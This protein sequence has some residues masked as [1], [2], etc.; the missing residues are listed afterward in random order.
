MSPFGNRTRAAVLALASLAGAAVPARAASEGPVTF[1]LEGTE[2]VARDSDGD[3]LAAGALVG[4]TFT[5]NDRVAGRYRFRI[6]QVLPDPEAPGRGALYDVS[7]YGPA[8]ARWD[9]LC[10]ADAEGRT[11]AIVV[12]GSWTA[13]GRFLRAAARGFS[14]ACTAGAEAK[15]VRFG[16]P[17]WATAPDGGGMAPYHAAC[18]RMVRADY[19]GDGTPHTV[20]GVTIQFFD[21]AAINARPANAYGAFEALWGSDGAVCMARSRRPEFPIEDILRRCPRLA[22]LPAT[23]CSAGA[24]ERLPGALLGNRS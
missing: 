22:A 3:A 17:P 13:D 19:C 24:I 8:E 1:A 10:A 7:V 15:C 5:I 9:K 16:Y 4:A 18:V 21:R 2:I 23:A 6:D 14:F 12:P 11:T 20:P